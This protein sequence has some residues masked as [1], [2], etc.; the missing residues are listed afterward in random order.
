MKLACPGQRAVIPRRH[1]GGAHVHALALERH[2]L[3]LQQPALALALG[4]RAVRAHHALPRHVRIVVSGQHGARVA[5]RLR[6]QVARKSSRGRARSSA[7]RSS[8]ARARGVSCP[9]AGARL[10]SRAGR[11]RTGRAP[12]SGRATPRCAWGRPARRGRAARAEPRRPPRSS[13]PAGTPR[14][15]GP[16]KVAPTTTPASSSTTRRVVPARVVAPVEARP[17]AALGRHLDRARVQA[18][19]LRRGERVADGRHLRIGERH[20]RRARAVE[21]Q[22]RVRRGRGS[23]R[24]RCAPG[25]CPCA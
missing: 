19:L 23:C 11:A 12:A 6:A 15:P 9:S 1:P 5:G 14:P 4:Q 13:P 2:A 3:R 16:V 18:R 21:D 8:T 17:G 22:A 10:R 25:T 20:P 24:P 7:R